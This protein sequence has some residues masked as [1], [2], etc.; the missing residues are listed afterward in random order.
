MT[1][2][3]AIAIIEASTATGNLDNLGL[4]DLAGLIRDA[5]NQHY[6]SRVGHALQQGR[7]LAKARELCEDPN[8]GIPGSNL[9]ERFGAYIKD[10]FGGTDL[11]ENIRTARNYRVLYETFGHLSVDVVGRI[12][13]TNCY[14]LYSAP[15]ALRA[16]IVAM[17]K[18]RRTKRVSAKEV[19]EILNPEPVQ[20]P[21]TE[22]ETA[23]LE[24]AAARA[25]E[26]RETNPDSYLPAEVEDAEIISETPPAPQEAAQEAEEAAEAPEDL[27]VYCSSLSEAQDAAAKAVLDEGMK[28]SEAQDTFG[29]TA[30]K[31]REALMFLSGYRMALRQN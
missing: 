26:H 19:E 27:R 8:C 4:A 6:H 15:P 18:R 3:N 10:N 22:A 24:Q 28:A 7:Y 21:A 2:Q 11:G 23:A 29:I 1:Q 16:E 9:N 12:G 30:P 5:E 31:L 20:A 13:L 17:A 14:K 25:A